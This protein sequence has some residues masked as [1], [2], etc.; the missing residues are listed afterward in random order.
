MDSIDI[1]LF[2]LSLADIA[3]YVYIE[4][5]N[6]VDQLSKYP[7]LKE[8]RAKVAAYPQIKAYLAARPVTD[9]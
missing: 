5:I 8:N 2:Q 6:S 7:K 4:G 3:L 1:F 9:F